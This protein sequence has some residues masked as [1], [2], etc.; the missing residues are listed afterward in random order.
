MN[1]VRH[2]KLQSSKLTLSN[3]IPKISGSVTSNKKV[4]RNSPG[5]IHRF[6]G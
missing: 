5:K 2:E 4:L 6:F 3:T 1:E